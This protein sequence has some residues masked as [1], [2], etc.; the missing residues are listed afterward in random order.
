MPD[1]ARS[2]AVKAL[3]RFYRDKS[4]SNILLEEELQKCALPQQDKALATTLF[5]GS[6]FAP[7]VG[8]CFC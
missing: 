7:S 5:Y 1:N 2:W 8:C 3:T 6:S 4:Y